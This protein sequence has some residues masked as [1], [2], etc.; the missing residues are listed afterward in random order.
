MAD[1]TFLTRLPLT[2]AL[3]PSSSQAMDWEQSAAQ[4][5]R[6]LH[7]DNI[8]YFIYGEK[9]KMGC[10]KNREE[11]EAD[12][13]IPRKAREVWSPALHKHRQTWWMENVDEHA[14]RSKGSSSCVKTVR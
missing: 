3:Q 14:R 13:Q 6:T 5:L 12:Q 7:L 1:E 4:G 8:K 11:D 10:G 2:P 9:I